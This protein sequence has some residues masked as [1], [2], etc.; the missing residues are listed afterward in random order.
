MS[1]H[2]FN[3]IEKASCKPF[4]YGNQGRLLVFSLSLHSIVSSWQYMS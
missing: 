3:S 2:R 1:G 4:Q